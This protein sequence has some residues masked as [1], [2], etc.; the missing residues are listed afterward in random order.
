MLT[1][2]QYKSHTIILVCRTSGYGGESSSTGNE[3]RRARYHPRLHPLA[4][5]SQTGKTFPLTRVFAGHLKTLQNIAFNI[6][7][8]RPIFS[9]L[10]LAFLNPFCYMYCTV[11][12]G[13]FT[14]NN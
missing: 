11:Y 14:S 7:I 5:T 4:S 9:Q 3:T 13:I 6:K 1:A 12:T 8:Y 2:I 10:N